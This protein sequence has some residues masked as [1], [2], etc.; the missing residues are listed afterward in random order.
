MTDGYDAQHKLLGCGEHLSTYDL[1]RHGI[2]V[3]GHATESL[4][5]ILLEI[6]DDNVYATAIV[7]LLYGYNENPTESA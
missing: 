2:M 5:Q 1:T 6:E 7:G 4:P 3:A